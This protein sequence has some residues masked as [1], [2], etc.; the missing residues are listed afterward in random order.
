MLTLCPYAMLMSCKK[1]PILKLCPV[2]T[3]IGDYKPPK[4]K[5]KKS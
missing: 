3:V 2:K 5:K 4:R 1:C